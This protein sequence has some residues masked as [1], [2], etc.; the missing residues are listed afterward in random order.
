M[1]PAPITPLDRRILEAMRWL[2]KGADG[3]QQVIDILMAKR[4]EL[5]EK[6]S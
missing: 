2:N 4:K 3:A 6:K 5:K 1:R